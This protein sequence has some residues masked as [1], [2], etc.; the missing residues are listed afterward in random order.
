[1]VRTVDLLEL[2][3][4]I[5]KNY[6]LLKVLM[7]LQLKHLQLAEESINPLIVPVL[8][9][10]VAIVITVIMVYWCRARNALVMGLRA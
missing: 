7:R 9:A 1:M 6:Q 10:V 2:R 3:H 4:F 8:I 5:N